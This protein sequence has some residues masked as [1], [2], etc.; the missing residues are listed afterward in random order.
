MLYGCNCKP[1]GE[2]RFMNVDQ[3]QRLHVCTDLVTVDTRSRNEERSQGREGKV[4]S[5]DPEASER[6]TFQQVA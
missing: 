2:Q 1:K 5:L 6:S 4:V 3:A